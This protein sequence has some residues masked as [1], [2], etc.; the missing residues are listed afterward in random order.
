MF[1]LIILA[2]LTF[3]ITDKLY[4]KYRCKTVDLIAAICV[5]VEMILIIGIFASL[6]FGE[7]KYISFFF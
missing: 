6:L 1:E 7:F 4:V 5:P 3:L 2:G